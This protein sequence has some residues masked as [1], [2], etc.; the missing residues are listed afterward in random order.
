MP[1]QR[2]ELTAM[3]A[4]GPASTR[5]RPWSH[6]NT[7]PPAFPSVTTTAAEFAAVPRVAMAIAA[8]AYI[9]WLGLY[10]D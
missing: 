4:R 5:T 10:K 6:G 7:T 2:A 3:P 8:V 9:G 1:A